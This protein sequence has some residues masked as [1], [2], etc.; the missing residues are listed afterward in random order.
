MP[1]IKKVDVPSVLL[2]YIYESV[3][4]AGNYLQISKTNLYHVSTEE[5]NDEKCENPDLILINET[6]LLITFSHQCIE[7]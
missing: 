7:K 6:K 2:F 1:I 5:T 3:V 4:T